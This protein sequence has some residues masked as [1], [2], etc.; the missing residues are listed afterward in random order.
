LLEVEL[1]HQEGSELFCLIAQGSQS[2]KIVL[3]PFCPCPL[4][5]L[6]LRGVFAVGDVRR[7]SIKRVSFA[8]AEGPIAISFV[9]H[10]LQELKRDQNPTNTG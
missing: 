8:V 7:D 3:P 6:S 9:H 2:G 1:G 10:V 5:A 4:L